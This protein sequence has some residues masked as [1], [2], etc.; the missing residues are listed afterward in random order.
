MAAQLST[1][2]TQWHKSVALSG[3]AAARLLARR[4]LTRLPEVHRGE[5]AT[6]SGRLTVLALANTLVTACG[7]PGDAGDVPAY[8]SESK[9]IR[10]L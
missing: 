10:A 4:L 8:D 9:I 3:K 1:G 6:Y 2:S 5:F 7:D